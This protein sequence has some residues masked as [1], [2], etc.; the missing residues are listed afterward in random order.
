MKIQRSVTGVED[1]ETSK[2]EFSNSECPNLKGSKQKHLKGSLKNCKAFCLEEPGCT[3]VNYEDNST[4]CILRGCKLPVVPP[5][6]NN[7]PTYD[8]Y[9][10]VSTGSFYKSWPQDLTTHQLPET[11]CPL[12]IHSLPNVCIIQIS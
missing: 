6:N 11:S 2:N 10:L 9:W 3:A 5:A 12:S 1:W 4:D 7:F 8:G